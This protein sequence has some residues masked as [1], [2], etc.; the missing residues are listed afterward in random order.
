MSLFI[1]KKNSALYIYL[2]LCMPQYSFMISAQT[3]FEQYV[4]TGAQKQ[5]LYILLKANCPYLSSISI[6]SLGHHYQGV[7][8]M[9]LF[10]P[11]GNSQLSL[12]LSCTYLFIAYINN[13]RDSSM[14]K[15]SGFGQGNSKRPE[16]SLGFCLHSSIIKRLKETLIDDDKLLRT[17]FANFV[18]IGFVSYHCE[19]NLIMEYY[20]PGCFS[21]QFGFDQDVLID[22]DFGNLPDLEIMLH[23]HY[24]LTRYRIES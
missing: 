3:L 7:F 13:L 15:F 17:D 1:V 10:L 18:S 6:V 22:L 14:V 8:M 12:S 11:N 23:C 2:M 4:S 24:M 21:R 16:N 5:T 20:Y 9:K 19:E